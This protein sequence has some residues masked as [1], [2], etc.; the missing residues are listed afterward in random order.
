MENKKYDEKT[1]EQIYEFLDFMEKREE[2]NLDRRF[3]L[4]EFRRNSK[5]PKSETLEECNKIE[6]KEI[7]SI[8]DVV[9]DIKDEIISFIKDW[10]KGLKSELIQEEHPV[11]RRLNA[12]R[13]KKIEIYIKCVDGTHPD[14]NLLKGTN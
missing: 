2:R 11:L 3:D 8:L 1:E 4:L 5:I 9:A 6:L 10:I 14:L 13:I 7:C 12:R